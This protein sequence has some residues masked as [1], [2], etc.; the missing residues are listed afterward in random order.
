[1]SN[2]SK[3][4][5]KLDLSKGQEFDGKIISASKIIGDLLLV[6]DRKKMIHAYKYSQSSLQSPA[7]YILDKA[8]VI[9]VAMPSSQNFFILTTK[10]GDYL[11]DG[12]NQ[13]VEDFNHWSDAFYEPHTEQ[14]FRK[15]SNG[16]WV[17]M[18]N[19][20]LASPIFISGTTLISLEAKKSITSYGFLG[21]KLL[22]SK[23]RKLIQLGKVVYNDQLEIQ[24]FFNKKIAGLTNRSVDL[25][26]KGVIVEVVLGLQ[27]NA[28]I[29]ENS[30]QPLICDDQP[31]LEYIDSFQGEHGRF[32]RFKNKTQEVSWSVAQSKFISHNNAAVTIDFEFYFIINKA[33]I[34]LTTQNEKAFY[35]NLT[36]ENIFTIK[37]KE[38]PEVV[39]YIDSRPTKINNRSYWNI[40]T[41]HKKYVLAEKDYSILQLSNGHLPE[42]LFDIHGL[43][44]LFAGYIF[45]D[46]KRIIYKKNLEVLRLGTPSVE[47]SEIFYRPDQKL[48]NA[49]DIHRSSLVIDARLGMDQMSIAHSGDHKLES[50]SDEPVEVGQAIWQNVK[51]ETLGGA[52]EIVINIDHKELLPCTLPTDLLAISGNETPSIFHSSKIINIDFSTSITIGKHKYFSSRI[53][54]FNNRPFNILINQ[55]DGRPLQ[56]EG[57]GLK[58]ELVTRIDED[59]NNYHLG[60]NT[61]IKVH[62]L[63]EDYEES[64]LLCTTDSLTSTIIFNETFLPPLKNAL[65]IKAETNW[66]YQLFEIRG[67]SLE[68][69]F[70]AVEKVAPYRILVE[71]KGKSEFPKIIKSSHDALRRPEEVSALRKLF[72][73]DPGYLREVR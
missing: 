19:H 50:I 61:L 15:T 59:Q 64:T 20:F 37:E 5:K 9:A 56:L 66:P 69:E 57:G 60:P 27:K 17:D 2:Q 18:E 54:S 4:K 8:P 47:I 52:T 24:Y 63:T 21:Q 43:K 23:N 73:D 62:T 70:I 46:T 72:F 42:S 31:F 55:S 49:K 10:L 16:Y 25:G 29:W 12:S 1:M 36:T 34:V 13:P 44:H 41:D 22:T 39:T 71:R 7:P 32:E 11:R 65:H 6:W 48:F 68:K 33:E 40:G 3:G 35:Y 30:G 26:K 53:L 28:F 14:F 45:E 58:N 51:I 38:N 67:V